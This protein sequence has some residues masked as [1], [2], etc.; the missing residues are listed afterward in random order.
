MKKIVIIE[1]DCGNWKFGSNINEGAVLNLKKNSHTLK[2]QEALKALKAP[3]ALKG[4]K[5]LRQR[6]K[7]QI[8]E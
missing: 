7:T 6:H 8:R 3:K 4:T 5:K 2:S 1:K